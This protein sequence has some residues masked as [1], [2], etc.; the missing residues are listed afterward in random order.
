MTKLISSLMLILVILVSINNGKAKFI[1]LKNGI[2]TLNKTTGHTY[3]LIKEI[4]TNKKHLVLISRANKDG[5]FLNYY[6]INGIKDPISA[7]I[8]KNKLHLIDENQVKVINLKTR[9]IESTSQI[10]SSIKW[11]SIH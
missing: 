6:P 10:S 11:K 9:M 8:Y 4:K 2:V 1:S 5:V 3:R 7:N